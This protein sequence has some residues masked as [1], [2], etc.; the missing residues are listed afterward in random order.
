[1][2]RLLE[3][4]LLYAK[5]LS[6]DPR[7]VELGAL[8]EAHVAAAGERHPGQP[9]RLERP[10]QRPAHALEVMADPDRL[11]QILTNL[12]DNA[13]EAAPAGSTVTWRIREIA[14]QAGASA[15]RLSV[16]NAGEPIPATLLPRLTEPF[17]STKASG[18]G[19]GLAIVRRLVEQQSGRLAIHST[20]E[21]GTRVEIDLPRPRLATAW[22]G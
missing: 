14:G 22:S 10:A 16:H 19:L 21:Q 20:A 12:T 11:Q 2:R 9:I 7:P 1:M 15:V 6:L 8:L 4:I 13:C 5:H 18:T 17:F 3:E